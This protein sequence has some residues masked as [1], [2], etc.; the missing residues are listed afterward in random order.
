MKLKNLSLKDLTKANLKGFIQGWSRFLIH[1]YLPDGLPKYQE[2]IILYRLS[3]M[4]PDC[5]KAGQ[6]PCTCTYPE[7]QFEDRQ[8]ENKCYPAMMSK[9]EWLD[10]KKTNNITLEQIHQNLELRKEYFTNVRI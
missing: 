10:Y 2:E 5:L 1:S 4:S 3:I 8:C 6:C 9:A 7:K